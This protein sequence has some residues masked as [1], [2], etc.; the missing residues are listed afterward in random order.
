MATTEAVS[1]DTLYEQDETAWLDAMSELIRLGR[2]D[3]IDFPNLAEYLTDMA[4]RDRREVR[5]RLVV[6]LMHLLKW[7]YQ[8]EKRS[9]R[10]RTT[11]LNQRQELAVLASRG[12]LRV[13]ATEVLSHAYKDAAE[14]A[15]SETKKRRDVFPVECPYSFDQLLAIEL[16][17]DEDTGAHAAE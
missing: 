16:A 6:L 15:A 10:W 12:V 3:E 9:Q 11:V 4:A 13:H 1:L 17:E 7:E 5:S 8:P 2:V 14:L